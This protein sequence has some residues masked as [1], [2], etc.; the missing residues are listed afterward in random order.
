MSLT[1]SPSFWNSFLD[2][3]PSF[4]GFGKLTASVCILNDAFLA[5]KDTDELEVMFQ[6]ERV[7]RY[8]KEKM[9][10]EPT[11]PSFFT[12][13]PDYC[14]HYLDSQLQIH[15]LNLAKESCFFVPLTIDFYY[16]NEQAWKDKL[17]KKLL[18]YQPLLS[19][20]S[21]VYFA[22]RFIEEEDFRSILPNTLLHQL[23]FR[24]ATQ[25]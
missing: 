5:A 14:H 7:N 20:F 18:A 3:N 17:K 1:Y 24:E 10:E 8:W 21:Q 25:A 4:A 12:Y 16:Q 15:K 11:T 22:S 6:L 23:H 13:L 2:A 19:S 9:E